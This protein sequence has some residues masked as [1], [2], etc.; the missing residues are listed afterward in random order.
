MK[1][2]LHRALLMSALV[3][4]LEASRQPVIAAEFH[5]PHPDAEI[6][7]LSFVQ[8]DVRVSEGKSGKVDLEGSWVQAAAGLSITK[9]FTIVTGT[10]RAEIEFENGWAAY[11]A[12]NSTLEFQTLNSFEE[13]PDTEL[14]LLSG[15]LTA[16]FKPVLGET[17]YVNGVEFYAQ[18]DLRFDSFLDG[19]SVTR[20]ELA[21]NTVP[22]RLFD[23]LP[24]PPPSD[25]YIGR[26]VISGKWPDSEARAEWNDWASAAESERNA[27]LAQAEKAS[28]LSVPI[29]GLADLYAEGEFFECAPYGKCWEPRSETVK[30]PEEQPRGVSATFDGV[31]TEQSANLPPAASQIVGFPGTTKHEHFTRRGVNADC[32]ITLESID[33]DPVTGVEKV[34]GRLDEQPAPWNSAVCHAGSFIY[35]PRHGYVWVAGKK[36]HHNPCQYV[37]FHGKYGTVP[38]H[39]LDVKGKTPLNLTHGILMASGRVSGTREVIKVNM[40]EKVETLNSVP[41]EF[42]HPAEHLP[43][44]VARPR[45]EGHFIDFAGATP[46]ILTLNHGNSSG[47]PLK[48]AVGDVPITYDYA[49]HSFVLQPPGSAAHVE[50]PVVI[51]RVNSYGGIRGSGA[52]L[53]GGPLSGTS[54]SRGGGGVVAGGSRSFGGGHS[55]GAGGS[56]GSGFS[57]GSHAGGSGG[58]HSGGGGFS[59]GGGGHSGGGG[60]SGGGGGSYSGGGE[61]SGGGVGNAGGG[62]AGGGGGARPR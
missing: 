13:M 34:V 11:L 14:V 50:S 60:Y 59:G 27:R 9:G 53:S 25:V 24:P 1:P 18:S 17:L 20:E 32:G 7:R 45:I 5:Q 6:V 40:N 46:R 51:A 36:H 62:G 47:P 35:L 26:D 29:P 16:F 22:G 52:G 38:W 12:D 41:R 10:G 19:F 43:T 57:G 4:L 39:P 44:A 54:G 58:G 30:Q 8:G 21:S 15:T 42:Q 55:S 28:G 33:R 48:V 56:G 31:A 2:T 3:F 37:K 49:R 23:F 61:H